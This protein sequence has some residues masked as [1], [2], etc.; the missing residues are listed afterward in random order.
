M[1]ATKDLVLTILFC[2]DDAFTPE[3]AAETVV[4]LHAGLETQ[5]EN[6]MNQVGDV[7]AAVVSL[8]LFHELVTEAVGFNDYLS[9][10]SVADGDMPTAVMIGPSTGRSDRLER[11][12]AEAKTASDSFM[13]HDFQSFRDVFAER[14]R[15]IGQHGYD[16]ANDDAY[17]AGELALAAASYA[18]AHLRP[19]MSPALY[20]WTNSKPSCVPAM[21]RGNLVKA[22]ALLIAEIERL[23]RA[24]P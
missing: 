8:A 15:Q 2:R 5:A 10:H 4:A 17:R 6:D 23:D 16:T 24:A 14:L 19:S 20:P 3:R 21:V 7:R 12:L 18:L 22:A 11:A 1:G 13:A 9:A